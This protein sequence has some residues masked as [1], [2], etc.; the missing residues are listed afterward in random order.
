M[1]VRKITK[2]L[3]ASNT[4]PYLI[5]L[6]NGIFKHKIS[7]GG[8]KS[9]QKYQLFLNESLFKTLNSVV[10]ILTRQNNRS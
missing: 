5:G 4:L 8:Q 3:T 7:H 10:F 6:K 9:A 2:T 1:Y